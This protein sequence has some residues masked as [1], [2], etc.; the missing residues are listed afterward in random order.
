MYESSPPL[1]LTVDHDARAT[2]FTHPN[3]V[4][5]LIFTADAADAAFDDDIGEESGDEPT[6]EEEE[7]PSLLL[8]PLFLGE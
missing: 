2:P 3:G 8:V 1:L 5:V 7:E 6:K 4:W